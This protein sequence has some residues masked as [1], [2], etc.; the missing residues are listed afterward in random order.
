VRKLILIE[1][2]SLDGVIQAPGGPDEDREGGF[3]HGGWFM[4]YG[5]E[6]VGKRTTDTIKR[7]GALLLG[8]V[9]Y[10][11]F[12]NYWPTAPDEAAEIR[13]PFNKMHHYV[14]SRSMVE[15]PWRDTTVIR[16]VP[17]EVADLKRQPGGDILVYGSADLAQTLM[18]HNL[19]DEYELKV[20]P[21]VLGQG[22]RLF[23]DDNGV[24]G[25]KLISHNMTSTG[26]G[27]THDIRPC[28][29]TR[30]CRRVS[31]ERQLRGTSNYRR[32][33]YD[34]RPDGILTAVCLVWQSRARQLRKMRVDR[35]F[36]PLR[37]P[38]RG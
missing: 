10:G 21:I 5:N 23:R 3:Q 33:A 9:T 27:R 32:L 38:G 18:R 37:L 12:A 29:G 7:A 36:R 34:L 20:A 22:K 31:R 17:R 4:P 8:R 14:A 26:V 15:G 13:D 19:I 30:R 24:R 1:M 16:D 6:A 28:T 35:R 11:I 2:I 25:F